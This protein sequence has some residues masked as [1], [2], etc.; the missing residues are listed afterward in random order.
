MTIAQLSR[1]SGVTEAYIYRVLAEAQNPSLKIAN[2]L[3]GAV[4]M[5][6]VL[7]KK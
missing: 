7:A 4:K 5:H 1:D 3:A 2:K 6:L